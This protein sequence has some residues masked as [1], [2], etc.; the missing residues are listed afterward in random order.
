[1]DA[2]VEAHDEE[3]VRRA[4]A[5]GAELIG[6]NNRDLTTLEVDL[7]TTERL[8]GLVP[9][10][11]IL[12]SESG[13]GSRADVER[14]SVHADAFL[15]GSSLMR[16]EDPAAAARALAFG[17]VKVCGLTNAED[18]A[19]AAA[20]GASYA[21]IVMVPGTPRAVNSSAA[22]R[23]AM[24]AAE[25]GIPLVAVFR[26]E[27]LAEVA[28]LAHRLRLR[29]VQLHGQEDSSYI[30][31]LKTMLPDGC[32]IWAAG[33]VSD[34]EPRHGAHRR[35]FDSV[36]GGVSGGTGQ[37]FDWS[38]LAGHRD[39]AGAVLAGGL[40]PQN[41]EAASKVGAY[42]LDVSSGVE[43]TPGEKD[44]TRLQAFFEA[45]RLPVRHEVKQC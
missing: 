42:A 17:T 18:I 36:V 41:A 32:E 22:D 34:S 43:Q 39:L 6:I 27:K 20:S 3:E 23:L 40:N 21:G 9:G 30:G 33:E 12:V 26:N 35:L 37:T 1:M 25:A 11:R 28:Q 29:A 14:L 2:L 13:I 45:L 31:A 38:R 7:D 44:P 4:V 5:L 16:A 24:A 19:L 8:A 15:V 10:D